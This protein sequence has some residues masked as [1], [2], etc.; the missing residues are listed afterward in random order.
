MTLQEQLF[1]W[2]SSCMQLFE[3][4]ET[5]CHILYSLLMYC[6]IDCLNREQVSVF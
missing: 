2:F 5:K 4:N 6:C 3:T 1:G